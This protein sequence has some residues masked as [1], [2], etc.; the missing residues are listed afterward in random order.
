MGKT[1][2]DDYLR[3]SRVTRDRT[4]PRAAII[5]DEVRKAER[6]SN[7]NIRDMLEVEEALLDLEDFEDE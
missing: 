4:R 5:E 7:R 1:R 3:A 2:K 6:R